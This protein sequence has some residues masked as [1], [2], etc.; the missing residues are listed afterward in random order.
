MKLLAIGRPK[1]ENL[2]KGLKSASE[3]TVLI[4]G[5]MTVVPIGRNLFTVLYSLEQL[6]L[7]TDHI[8]ILTYQNILFNTSNVVSRSL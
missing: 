2:S 8:P 3:R 4:G 5:L 7:S 6:Q 1:L